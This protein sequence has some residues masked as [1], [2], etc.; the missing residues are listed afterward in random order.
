M[1][2]LSSLLPVPRKR[3]LHIGFSATDFLW[4]SGE[5]CHHHMSIPPNF[6]IKVTARDLIY[7]SKIWEDRQI[8]YTQNQGKALNLKEVPFR[9]E[10]GWYIAFTQALYL[11]W[12]NTN[13]SNIYSRISLC[14]FHLR[15]GL[16]SGHTDLEN[17]CTS[18][19]SSSSNMFEIVIF[20]GSLSI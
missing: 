3:L 7:S 6:E 8:L 9:P 2:D 15:T 4:S 12:K 19:S 11:S 10:K 5:L 17:T 16:T 13:K 1:W 14:T 20:L 18:W